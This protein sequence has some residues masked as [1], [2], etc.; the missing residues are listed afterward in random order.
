M[1]NPMDWEYCNN[2]VHVSSNMV[3]ATTVPDQE[4][5]GGTPDPAGGQFLPGKTL[6]KV[7]RVDPLPV[8]A[9]VSQLLLV[10]SR[11]R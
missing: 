1:V 11:G 9:R 7:I 6:A 8:S 5:C 3:S 4:V 2:P 10:L